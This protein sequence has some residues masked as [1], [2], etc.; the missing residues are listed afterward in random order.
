VSTLAAPPRSAAPSR[1][2]RAGRVVAA[3]VRSGFLAGVVAALAWLIAGAIAGTAFLVL[4]AATILVAGV[5]LVSDRVIPTSWWVALAAA[6]A[7]VLIERWAVGDHGGVWV[8]AAAWLGI[9]TG[10]RGA[11]IPRWALPLL[12]YPL[13]S[14]AIA[15]VA[16]QPL[17][18]PWGVSWLW[19]AAVLGPPLGARVLLDPSPRDHGRPA[20]T[21]LSR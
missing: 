1:R 4:V 7:V 14:V 2:A 13:I 8:A 17:L 21:T 5:T 11:G 10:A 6:W 12:A 19:V 9:V 20:G 18:H 15:I 16:G 3:A